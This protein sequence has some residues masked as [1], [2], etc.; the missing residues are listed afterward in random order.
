MMAEFLKNLKDGESSIEREVVSV[1]EKLQLCDEEKK[2][3]GKEDNEEEK[4]KEEK[5]IHEQ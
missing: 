5:K 1:H 3:S 2:S 4:I